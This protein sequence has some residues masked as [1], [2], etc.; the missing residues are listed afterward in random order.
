MDKPD[1]PVLKHFDSSISPDGKWIALN[2]IDDKDAAL[3][4]MA[5][6]GQ[7]GG[8]VTSL[9]EAAR[10]A[11]EIAPTGN[12]E[13]VEG[14]PLTVTGLGVGPGRSNSEAILSI[15]VGPLTLLFGVEL[16]S[17][18]EMGDLLRSK[19]PRLPPKSH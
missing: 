4:C 3:R 9:L 15:S 18:L 5:G 19:T 14:T 10:K 11:A 16:A 12:R 1:L 7:L 17:L 13:V 2:V 8:V 6:Q